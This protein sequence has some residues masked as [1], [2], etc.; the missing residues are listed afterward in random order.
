MK[1]NTRHWAGITA[2]ILSLTGSASATN[3]GSEKYTYDASGNIIEKSIDGKVT[4]FGY[5][6]SNRI[7]ERKAPDQSKETTIY[8]AAGRPIAVKDDHDQQTRSLAYGYGDKVLATRTETDQADFYYN[9]EGQMVGKKAAGKVSSY[10]WDG[11]VLAAD[12]VQA[13]TNEAHISGG[14]PVLIAGKAVV[15]DGLGSTLAAGE[16]QFNSTAY[17]EGLEEGRFTGKPFVKELG[18]YVFNHRLYSPETSRWTVKDPLGFPDGT[19]NYTYVK[20]NP[21]NSV[22]P[23]GTLTFTFSA[24]SPETV[25]LTGSP[26]VQVKAIAMEQRDRRSVASGLISTMNGGL[27]VADRWAVTVSSF[28]M[29]GSVSYSKYLAKKTSDDMGGTEIEFTYSSLGPLTGS[30]SGYSRNVIQTVYSNSPLGS[31]PANA[32]YLDN[33]GSTSSPFYPYGS[34]PTFYD[35]SQRNKSDLKCF[36]GTLDEVNWTGDNNLV[37]YDGTSGHKAILMHASSSFKWSWV[38][39]EK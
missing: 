15:S 22:D 21:E 35:W 3:P 33:S 2:G 1:T 39:K 32:S 36:G 13:F 9:A 28:A 25:T 11:N 29:G 18:N 19:N 17:G 31:N 14:V 20:N 10:T 26:D 4:E 5:D 34:I 12:D 24:P 38:M 23:M 27:A 37:A 30:V 6:Q 8:D 16:Q 7:T